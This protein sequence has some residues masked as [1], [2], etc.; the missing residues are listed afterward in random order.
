M[1]GA[2]SILGKSAEGLPDDYVCLRRLFEH[3]GDAIFVHGLDGL[4]TDVNIAASSILGYTREELLG[5]F[6]WNF[7][8]RDSR[9]QILALWNGMSS[10]EPITVTDELRRKDGKTFPAEVRLVRYQ[11]GSRDMIIAI[12]RDITKR[13]EAEAAKLQAEVEIVKERN[14]MAREIHDTLAQSFAGI[15][16]QLE[17]AEAAKESGIDS[18]IYLQRIRETANFGLDEARR[19]VLALRTAALEDGGLEQALQ[20]LAERSSIKGSL[21]CQFAAL[22]FAQRVTPAK[23][24]G[25]FRIAQEAVGNAIKH[26]KASRISIELMVTSEELKLLVKDDGQGIAWDDP[27]IHN[28]FGLS[29]MRER[30]NDLGAVIQIENNPGGGTMLRLTVP[31]P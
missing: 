2:V 3:A 13:R 7:V 21:I 8:V 9:E 27:A 20:K 23:E 16:L 4:F 30:A 17:A 24:L 26:A 25:I 14:R 22:G 29:A 31:L 12:C 19:S 10:G 15:V 6:P 18:E 11:A 1:N 5:M 28:G